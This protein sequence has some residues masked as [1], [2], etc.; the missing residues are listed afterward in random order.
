MSADPSRAPDVSPSPDTPPAPKAT[1]QRSPD[2]Q[3]AVIRQL[4]TLSWP[5]IGL[6]LM[7]VLALAVDTAFC[8]RLPDATTALTALGYSTQLLFLL[9][10]GMMGLTVGTVAVVARA[11][12]A[13]DRE[14]VD[15]ALQ[16][17]AQLS[18][19]LGLL[20]AVVGNLIAAPFVRVLG[21]SE[22]VVECATAYLRP[23]LLATALPYL[24]ILLGAVL[25]GV[26]NTRLA[27]QI[28]LLINGLNALFNYV[29]VLGRFGAPSLGVEGA[30]YG[31]ILAYAIG[32]A[33]M[34]IALRSGREPALT[35]HLRPVPLDRPMV[36]QLLRI[37]WPAAADMVLV[38]AA[39]LSIVGMLGSIDQ[40]AVAAHGV[41]L[42]VQALAFVPGMAIAQATAALTGQALG[43]RTPERVRLVARAGVLLCL[44]VMSVLALILFAFDAHILAIFEIDPAG[45]LGQYA[46]MWMHELG[47]AMP[48]AGVH[49]ALVGVL[50]GAGATM[51]PLR[52][53]ILATTLQVP[54][55]WL[56]G[57]WMGWGPFGVWMAFPLS[58]LLRTALSARAVARHKWGGS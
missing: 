8:G 14:R 2:S 49:T 56:L 39:F 46:L 31:T 25:R 34:V 9:L 1:A 55:S 54:A 41:G 4:A 42:R 15:H 6:N 21:G 43:A 18:V 53:N 37:G 40:I 5:I 26:G 11:H 12:G 24:N 23:M 36:G 38:N 50:Q 44:S 28:A 19:L 32:V 52:I 16:Q 33:A 57:I 3:R 20:A 35:L 30:A 13:K 27:F 58:F 47:A 22:P 7:N 45:P 29:L 10:V 51:V 48:V 17:G